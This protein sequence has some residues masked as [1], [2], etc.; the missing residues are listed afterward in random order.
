MRSFPLA[1]VQFGFLHV[2]RVLEQ[3]LGSGFKLYRP[4]PHR[5]Q[6]Q[7]RAVCI[8]TFPALQ[9]KHRSGRAGP[10]TGTG[11]LL[12]Q[13]QPHAP[14]SSGSC[15]RLWGEGRGH[16]PVAVLGTFTTTSDVPIISEIV[17]LRKLRLRKLK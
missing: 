6:V 4:V 12:H 9:N 10:D 11:R 8:L 2:Q 5:E 16:V 3:G 13:D 1:F 7:R 17:Q 15:S 14:R